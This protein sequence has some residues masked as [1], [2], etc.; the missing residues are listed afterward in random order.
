MGVHLTV[1]HTLAQTVSRTRRI[2][3]PVIGLGHI[4]AS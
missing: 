3:H 4:V 2:G 1:P